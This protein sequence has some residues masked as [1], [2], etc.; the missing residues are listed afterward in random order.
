MFLQETYSIEDCLYWNDGSSVGS[1]EVGSNVSCTSNG[2]YITITT[3]TNG[4]KYVRIPV[5]LANTDN[6]IYEVEIADTGTSQPIALNHD[7]ASKWAGH[8]ISGNQWFCNSGTNDTYIQAY[9]V[10]DKLAILRENGV[11]TCILNDSI[12]IS[13]R[14][15]SHNSTF[16]VGFYTNRNRTQKVKNIKLN[17][18]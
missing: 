16:K 8:S 18:L 17:P 5:T 4:E 7:N 6:W 12:T 14:S 9:Q 10:G 13:N 1:L 15:A 2:D 3:S 11:D